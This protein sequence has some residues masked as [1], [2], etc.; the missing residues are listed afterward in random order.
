MADKRQSDRAIFLSEKE[1]FHG[2]C[3][4]NLRIDVSFFNTVRYA[5]ESV[6]QMEMAVADVTSE[7]INN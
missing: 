6:Q 5:T 7:R 3:V 1:C 2:T 4:A